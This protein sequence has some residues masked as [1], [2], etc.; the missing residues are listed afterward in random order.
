MPAFRVT[1]GVLRGALVSDAHPDN[2]LPGGGPGGPVDP[3]F[4]GGIGAVPDPGWGIPAPP[5]GVWPP[6]NA[7]LPIVPAPPGVPPGAIWPPP[8]YPSHG[9]PIGPGHPSGGFPVGPGHPDAGLPTPPSG[10]LPARPDA[11]PDHSLPGGQGGVITN[12]I[13]PK[14][15]WMLA[16]CPA[17][18]WNFVAVDPSLGVG[19]PLP[20][21]AEPK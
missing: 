5:P 14:V 6:P 11:R 10:T 12:P 7:T 8:G 17:L 21:H 3:G 19:Y 2:T 9:L 13:Q 20:P 1:G 18:G 15:Y 4:G 16:Y